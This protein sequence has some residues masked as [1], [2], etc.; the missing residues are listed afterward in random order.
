ME[1]PAARNPRIVWIGI[2][3]PSKMGCPLHISGW[4]MIFFIFLKVKLFVLISQNGIEP[5]PQ[6]NQRP[7]H[8]N[9]WRVAGDD[10]R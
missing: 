1:S 8:S 3:V 10:M 2:R 7:R 4:T 5:R 9:E 6:R